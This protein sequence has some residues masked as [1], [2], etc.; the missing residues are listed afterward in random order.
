MDKMNGKLNFNNI[1]KWLIFSL[2]FVFVTGAFIYG[3]INSNNQTFKIFGIILFILFILGIITS[4]LYINKIK[5]E[6]INI[7]SFDL[8]F[9]LIGTVATYELT[10]FLSVSNVL[11]SALIGVIGYLITKKY[12]MAIYAGS[13]S[14][15]V[16]QVLFN[17]YELI[18]LGLITGVIYIL[19]KTVCYG[20][21]GRLGSIAF[22]SNL[23]TA[24]ILGYTI[25]LPVGDISFIYV[26]IFSVVGV[27]SA[28]L[29]HTKF[30]QSPVLAS[31]LPSLFVAFVIDYFI[32][33]MG[34][35][36]LVFFAASFV[37]MS[38]KKIIP[39]WQISL[40]TGLILAII[41]L[42]FYNNFNGFGGKLGFMAFVSTIITVGLYR[43]FSYLLDK[44][45]RKEVS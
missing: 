44:I 40:F 31:A 19:I 17:H 18:L 25:N 23:I 22:I 16:S 35:Y 1:Q 36:S 5:V 41:F 38:E 33:S 9:V 34:V 43:S 42:T 6:K 15:M 39:N 24:I 37:G 29:L 11:A 27:V 7:K 4:I 3:I 12:A 14:G 32:P 2:L 21:G 30:N 28:Y 13:F 8:L 26:I 20:F 10:V 45:K